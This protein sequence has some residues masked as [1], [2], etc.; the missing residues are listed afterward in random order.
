MGHNLKPVTHILVL[1]RPRDQS[2][3][4]LRILAQKMDAVLYTLDFQ[5]LVN[6]TRKDQNEWAEGLNRLAKSTPLLM[7]ITNVPGI[8]R[9]QISQEYQQI[10]SDVSE[11]VAVVSFAAQEPTA[12]DGIF[13]LVAKFPNKISQ[14]VPLEWVNYV[15]DDLGARIKP[16]NKSQVA[17]MG[18]A[19]FG[20]NG[21]GGLIGFEQNLIRGLRQ[22][23]VEES[24]EEGP[25]GEFI[26]L[27]P[28]HL[29][30][31]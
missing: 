9:E 4:L 3:R 2:T 21:Q 24:V 23:L 20:K 31:R 15:L 11:D 5:S 8:P 25:E 18:V 30:R 7:Q 16:M 1:A 22:A 10:F 19:I 13:D 28:T 6:A 29:A 17:Q 26:V 12:S 14:Q 27:Q